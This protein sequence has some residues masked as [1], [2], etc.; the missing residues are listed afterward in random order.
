MTII[1]KIRIN[2]REE[3]RTWTK[4]GRYSN[5]GPNGYDLMP[6]VERKELWVNIH[7]EHAV[8]WRSKEDAEYLAGPGRIGMMRIVIEGDDFTVEKVTG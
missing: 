3:V 1:G 6:P 2:G 5:N 8:I 4:D 7:S